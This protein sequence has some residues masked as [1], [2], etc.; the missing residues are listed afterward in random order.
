MPVDAMP[1]VAVEVVRSELPA[2]D[3]LDLYEALVAVRPED[4][5]FLFESLAGP[6]QDCQSTAVGWGRLADLRV[7]ADRVCLEAA[8]PLGDAL[9][10]VIDGVLGPG[11]E[12]QWPLYEGSLAWTVLRAVQRCF[13]VDTD[14]PAD[15]FAFGFLATFSYES[16]WDMDELAP[17]Q[18][19]LEV[20]RSTLTLFQ[21][22][23]WY[24][25]A[26]ASRYRLTAAGPSFPENAEPLP[27]TAGDTE[28]PAVPTPDA[29]RTGVDEPLF[30][31]WAQRCLEHIRVGDVYQIQIGHAIEVDSDLTPR[32]VYRRLRHR[33]PS[34]YMYLL[35]W[36]GR[37]VI[38]ASPELFIRMENDR[39]VMRPIAGTTSRA[40]TAAEDE[41]RVAALLASPKE[42]AEHVMLV[43]LCR[44]DIGRVCTP[45]T[46]AVESM[47]EVEP[48]AYV[49]HLVSTIS[50]A[51]T[52]GI[53]VWDA[54]CATFPAGTMTGAPKLRAM[55]IIDEIEG[56]G[57]GIYS[58]ALGLIDTR[59]QATLAL[60]IRTIVHQD[61][62]YRTQASAGIVAD[63]RPDAEWRETLAKM[64]AAYWALTGEEL[65]K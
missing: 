5:V 32:Q 51:V 45:G 35:P 49:H 12:R 26:T 39:L 6:E 15:Q 3:A 44:N 21:H 37:T 29:V 60:C 30:T 8:G 58:G 16:A 56:V 20:P 52:P 18:L 40:A 43:D 11:V 14:V 57:R 4:D 42:R 7:F 17:R 53:D 48:F 28:V 25:L 59:G 9:A 46:L 54:L 23:A 36:A 13:D 33:N 19:D 41:A 47:M 22:T 38:G 1:R 2:G 27:P 10:E 64:S 34:P 55:E 61:R 65:L 63:S 31:Q 62:T 50:A 24:D